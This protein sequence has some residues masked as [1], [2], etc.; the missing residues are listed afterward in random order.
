[1]KTLLRAR[2]QWGRM[3]ADLAD[4]PELPNYLK[5][6]VDAFWSLHG[7]RSQGGPIHFAAVDAIGRRMGISGEAFVRFESRIRAC[8]AAYLQFAAERREE[9]ADKARKEAERNRR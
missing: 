1:M 7:D 3:P 4:R 8:D 5:R 2:R 9:E 6:V